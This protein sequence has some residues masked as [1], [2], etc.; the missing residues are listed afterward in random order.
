MKA[1]KVEKVARQDN[2]NELHLLSSLDHPNVV[3]YF[4]DFKLEM[5]ISGRVEIKQ[6]IVTELCQ[7]SIDYTYLRINFF[8]TWF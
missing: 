5:L 4:D 2:D 3:K 6:C 7:V 8:P 1:L